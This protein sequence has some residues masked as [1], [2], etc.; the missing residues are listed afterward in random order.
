[1]FSPSSAALVGFPASFLSLLF[2]LLATAPAPAAARFA[3]ITF[4]Q[5][6]QC[7]QFTVDFVGGKAPAALPLTLSILPLNGTPIFLPLPD[8][9]WNATTQIGDAI[10]F[11]PFPAGTEFI[12]SLDDANGQGTALVSDVLV[13]EPSDSNDT[14]CLPTNPATFVAQYAVEGTLQQCEPFSVRFNSSQRTSPT[15]RAFNPKGASFPV[16]QS[17]AFDDASGVA[18]YTM[19][20]ERDSQVI[21]LFK[22][23]S[24]YAETSQ[25]LP[26]FGDIQSSTACI[27]TNP[28]ANAATLESTA[29]SSRVTPKI[30]VIVIAVCGGVVA[31]VAMAMVAWCVIHRRKARAQK[32]TK[33]AEAQSPT[34]PAGPDPE[35][36]MMQAQDPRR[37]SPPPRI[38]TDVNLSPISPVDAPYD[39]ITRYLRNPPYTGMTVGSS[40]HSPSS[41]DPFG[42]QQMGSLLGSLSA[43]ESLTARMGLG[44]TALGNT[45]STLLAV[46]PARESSTFAYERTPARSSAF[47][48]MTEQMPGT[49]PYSYLGRLAVT[50]DNSLASQSV[51]RRPAS[52]QTASTVSSQ[53][54]DHILEM[55]TIYGAAELPDMPRAAVTAP[56]TIR[57]SAYMAGRESRVVSPAHGRSPS[58]S[59]GVLSPTLTHQTSQS[60]LRIGAGRFREPPLATL[61]MSPLPSPGARPSFDIDGVAV[62]DSGLSGLQAPR[63]PMPAALLRNVSSATRASVYSVDDGLDDFTMLQPPPPR[64]MNSR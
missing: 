52:V 55:A 54:I 28:L 64:R 51:L 24:G 2:A 10:A 9:A 29:S 17:A 21:L 58:A 49:S 41:P 32:F 53:E 3:S 62:R 13:V 18:N 1:M 61:P 20:A 34:A 63:A 42:E 43:R 5:V 26:V 48:P 22:D 15:V 8:N 31:I 59:T 47:D 35:K 46:P 30:A 23:A 44:A 56:A 7:G 39:D 45:G 27:P 6:K 38:A 36:Q 16:N 14:S 12:A 60:T 50:P 19:D 57:S 25:P 11:V 4:S 33:L 37:V 40:L